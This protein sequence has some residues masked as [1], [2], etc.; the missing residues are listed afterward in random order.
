MRSKIRETI[1]NVQKLPKIRKKVE[2]FVEDYN[3]HKEK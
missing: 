2:Q 3:L 1:T